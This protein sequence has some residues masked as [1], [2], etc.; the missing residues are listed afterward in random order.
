MARAEHETKHEPFS[1]WGPM[2]LYRS[3]GHK[4]GTAGTTGVCIE[5]ENAQKSCWVNGNDKG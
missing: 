4:A 1:V 3:H 2:Q 5:T